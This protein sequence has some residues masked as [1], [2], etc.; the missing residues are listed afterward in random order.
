MTVDCIGCLLM[1]YPKLHTIIYPS[2]NAVFAR[3]T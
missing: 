1:T 3:I 2:I